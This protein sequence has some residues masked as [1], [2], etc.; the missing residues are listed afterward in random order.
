GF[1]NIVGLK[2]TK[3]R[4]STG[5]VVPAC[6]S[7]DCLSVFALTVTD[8]ETVAG[9]LEGFDPTD[10][11]SRVPTT[12][13]IYFSAKPRFGIPAELPWFGDSEAEQAWYKSLAQLTAMGAELIPLDFTPM[14]TLAQLLYG[15]PWVAER[16]AA[17]AEFMAEHAEKMNPVVRGIIAQAKNFS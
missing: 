10:G 3:G 6:R 9:V 5:G 15:G 17:V 4:F 11:Y 1:N 16:H 8:A 13:A 2:P 14:Q 12:P 7:L